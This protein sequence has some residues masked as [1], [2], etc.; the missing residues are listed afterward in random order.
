[1]S[2]FFPT[3]PHSIPG[4][5]WE[6]GTLFKDIALNNNYVSLGHLRSRYKDGIISEMSEMYHEKQLLE[7][8]GKRVGRL[9]DSS[10]HDV[11]LAVSE[12]EREGKKKAG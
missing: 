1:M 11:G 9:G 2:M 4:V 8:N 5:S 12:G 7:K 3:S 6:G 10:G